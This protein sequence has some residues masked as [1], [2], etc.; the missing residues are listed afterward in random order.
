M[1]SRYALEKWNF[2]EFAVRGDTAVRRTRE[3]GPR[4]NSGLSWCYVGITPARRS[5]EERAAA[6][7]PLIPY[8]KRGFFTISDACVLLPRVPLAATQGAAVRSLLRT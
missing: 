3:K 2:M 8:W 4:Y 6:F 5:S 7:R 1:D